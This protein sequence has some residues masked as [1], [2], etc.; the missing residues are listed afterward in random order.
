MDE[1]GMHVHEFNQL[2]I[3]PFRVSQPHDIVGRSFLTQ[4]LARTDAQ[5]LLNFVPRQCVCP[6][7]VA[8]LLIVTAMYLHPFLQIGARRAGK[9]QHVI[10]PE[11]QRWRAIPRLRSTVGSSL[12]DVPGG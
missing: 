7:V 5:G 6:R 1:D 11:N 9:I 4:Q 2:V 10:C 3:Q 8:D 12:G